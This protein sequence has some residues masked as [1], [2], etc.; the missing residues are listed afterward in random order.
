MRALEKSPRSGR[1]IFLL[2]QYGYSDVPASRI[3]SIFQRL[4]S[5]EVILTFAVDAFIN[6]ASDSPK[7]RRLLE[8]TDLPDLLKGRSIDSIKSKEKD[9]RLFIQSA[10]Y[11]ALVEQCGAKFFTD[12]LHSY[13]WAR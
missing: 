3:R 4:G 9:F 1:S 2:D 13:D 12:F 5:A 10:F 7:T 6:Y 8:K 11:E